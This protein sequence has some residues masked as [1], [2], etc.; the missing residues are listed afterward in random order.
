MARDA[1]K[2]S[3]LKSKS[4]VQ[5]KLYINWAE[6]EYMNM[7]TPNCR[8]SS[9]PDYMFYLIVHSLFA[10]FLVIP[11][12]FTAICRRVYLLALF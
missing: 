1:P 3:I 9:V 10:P 7:G 6:H 5:N 4:L 8:S 12:S 11:F 2:Q